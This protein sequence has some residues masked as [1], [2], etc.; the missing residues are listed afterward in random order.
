MYTTISEWHLIYTKR[1]K[2]KIDIINYMNEI[3]DNFSIKLN[4]NDTITDP[5]TVYLFVVGD[6]EEPRK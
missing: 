2:E 6:N 5:S 4:P 1:D 3:V